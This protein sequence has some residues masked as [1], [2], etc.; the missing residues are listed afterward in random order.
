M[1][2]IVKC[3]TITRFFHCLCSA[4]MEKHDFYCSVIPENCTRYCKVE[5]LYFFIAHSSI[6]DYAKTSEALTFIRTRES[7]LQMYNVVYSTLHY[8]FI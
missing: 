7:T 3:V 5:V 2:F 4:L 8:Y 6:E 1:I